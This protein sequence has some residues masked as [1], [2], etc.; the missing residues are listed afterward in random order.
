MISNSYSLDAVVVVQHRGQPEA[1]AG[2]FT[3]GLLTNAP[4]PEGAHAKELEAPYERPV[5]EFGPP[6]SDRPG[7]TRRS[8]GRVSFGAIAKRAA[9]A[10]YVGIFKGD[11]II[12]YGRPQPS[13]GF[14]GPEEIAFEPAAIRVRF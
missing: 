1:F 7:G 12:A 5:V 9:E 4:T 3:L 8:G 11:D 14:V 13:A 2:P 6:A 10:R